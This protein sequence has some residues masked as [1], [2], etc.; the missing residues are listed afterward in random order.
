MHVNPGSR[1]WQAA[2]VSQ[3]QT[4]WKY[5]GQIPPERDTVHLEVNIVDIAVDGDCV[6]VI[7]DGNLWRQGLRIYEVKGLALRL[8]STD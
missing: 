1:T 7:G 6:T 2:Y 3:N 8:L 4:Q 5:R